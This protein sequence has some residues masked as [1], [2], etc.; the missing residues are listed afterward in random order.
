MN[1]QE[2]S[3]LILKVFNLGQKRNRES[4]VWTR[5][6]GIFRV[7]FSN[8]KM[9]IELLNSQ[10]LLT[11][12]F[13]IHATLNWNNWNSIKLLKKILPNWK[14]VSSWI[15]QVRGN[16][17]EKNSIKI[18]QN[19]QQK[20]ILRIK[21]IVIMKMEMFPQFIHQSIEKERKKNQ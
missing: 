10:F 16:F 21:E 8:G 12:L 1:V 17:F 6:V 9:F 7:L 20:K 14:R 13:N 3:F 11:N 2:F 15:L 19:F 4:F 5:K 18:N